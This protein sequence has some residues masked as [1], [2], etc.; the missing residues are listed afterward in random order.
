[1]RKQRYVVIYPTTGLLGAIGAAVVNLSHYSLEDAEKV[2]LEVRNK[3]RTNRDR[4][5]LAVVVP[6]M[7][8][9]SKWVATALKQYVPDEWKTSV[10]KLQTL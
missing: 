1:M 2:A 5:D 9:V 3:G 4:F 10:D 6:A 7:W 8:S